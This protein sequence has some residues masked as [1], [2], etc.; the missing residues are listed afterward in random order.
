VA[1]WILHPGG[2]CILEAYRDVFSLGDQALRWTRNC[3]ANVGNLSSASVLFT[4]ADVLAGGDPREGDRGFM[5][6]LGPGFASEMLL[7]QW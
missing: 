4:L 7:L 2:R 5:I 3:L 1:F 6:A